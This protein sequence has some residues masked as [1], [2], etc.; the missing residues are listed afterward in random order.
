MSSGIFRDAI[1]TD[2]SEYPSYLISLTAK[3]LASLM[4]GGYITMDARYQRGSTKATKTKAPLHLRDTKA[5]KAHVTSL[6]SDLNLGGKNRTTGRDKGIFP[7][8]WLNARRRSDGRPM[9]FFDETTSNLNYTEKTLFYEI[10]GAHRNAAIKRAVRDATV[11]PNRRFF[12]MILDAPEAYEPVAFRKLNS[13]LGAVPNRVAFLSA[14]YG[15][16]LYRA[17]WELVRKNRHFSSIDG[18]QFNFENTRKSANKY[19]LCHFLSITDGLTPWTDINAES[20]SERN[21]LTSY[22]SAY[23]DRMVTI[24]PDLGFRSPTER[25]KA[26]TT[27]PTLRSSAVTVLLRLARTYLDAA[28]IGI[29]G[30]GLTGSQ[31][32]LKKLHLLQSTESQDLLFSSLTRLTPSMFTKGGHNWGK[33]S[34]SPVSGGFTSGGIVVI[35]GVTKELEN[36]I[37]LTATTVI[38]VIP[39]VPV[40]VQLPLQ[41]SS[42]TP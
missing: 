40:P 14:P 31:L 5:G 36:V 23:W 38:N 7:A 35:K 39:K 16:D 18:R 24:L 19:E 15:Q 37:G 30:F 10:D 2:E 11:D 41:V 1:P 8:V 27:Y 29:Q 12:V 6:A 17:A 9:V 32:T 20:A 33:L 42:E 3:N 26:Y 22:L 4:E 25:A 13:Q 28:D 34:T 21:L